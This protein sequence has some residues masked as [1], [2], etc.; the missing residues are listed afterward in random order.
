MIYK[1]F[2]GTHSLS[3]PVDCLFIKYAFSLFFTKEIVAQRSEFAVEPFIMTYSL[4]RK[5][6]STFCSNIMPTNL[7]HTVEELKT[8]FLFEISN[9]TSGRCNKKFVSLCPLLNK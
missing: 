3:P 9:S 1:A 8:K 7:F 2:S 4:P 6:V 5:H